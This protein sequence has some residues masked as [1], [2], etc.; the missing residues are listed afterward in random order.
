MP[1]CRAGRGR[2]ERPCSSASWCWVLGVAAVASEGSDRGALAAAGSP[3]DTMSP[4]DAGARGSRSRTAKTRARMLRSSAGLTPA[5]LSRARA[6]GK[7]EGRRRYRGEEIASGAPDR[8]A[9]T[10]VTRA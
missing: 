4:R 2:G 8:S 9:R 3:R 7:P 6:A 1:L 5:G 10:G